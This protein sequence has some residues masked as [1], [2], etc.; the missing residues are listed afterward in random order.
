MYR[1]KSLLSGMIMIIGMVVLLVIAV[2]FC[3]TEIHISRYEY[4]T[5]W[6]V[7][8]WM[9]AVLTKKVERT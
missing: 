3:F 1:K 6:L 7:C 9:I 8:I 2:L 5:V 4:M